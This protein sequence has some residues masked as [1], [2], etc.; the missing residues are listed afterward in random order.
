ML[1]C[2]SRVPL[3][4]QTFQVIHNFGTSPDGAA[5]FDA[6]TGDGAGNL[7]GVTFKGPFEHGCFLDGCGT[8]FKLSPNADGT[9]TETILYE[10]TG[11]SD[12]LDP[13]FP[14]AIDS[15]G[16][17]YG[18]SQG[19]GQQPGTVFE[20]V[21]KSDGSYTFQTLYTF[22]D[23]M[24]GL[25]PFGVMLDR[26][27]HVFGT[28]EFGGRFNRGVVFRLGR[29]SVLAWHENV[30]LGFDDPYGAAGKLLL[31]NEGNIY[32]TAYSGGANGKGSVFKLTPSGGPSGWTETVLY[33]FGDR[34]DGANPYAGVVFDS[35]GNLYGTTEQGGG[36]GCGTVFE[37]TPD[38]SGG[39]NESVLYAFQGENDGCVVDS[40]VTFDSAGNLY[41]TTVDGGPGGARGTVFQLTPSIGGQ[42]SKRLLHSFTG[43]DGLLAYDDGSVYVDLNNN[44]YGTAIIGGT[45]MHCSNPGSGCGVV[46][47]ITP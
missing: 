26:V 36:A 33:S 27:G 14:V 21:R 4:A 3:H 32:G 41:G 5:P 16:N 28:T 42:W 22:A 34:P 2:G 23:S 47:Q 18:T 10:F 39:W 1:L 44:V 7:Y 45:G 12:G 13:V 19:I 15:K 8:V 40:G 38:S 31:D 37:L 30:L 9:W 43:P 25:Q 35:M 6:V 46:W 24:G 11:G 17:V 29:V 20:L